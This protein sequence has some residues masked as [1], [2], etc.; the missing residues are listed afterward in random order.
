MSLRVRRT[1]RLLSPWGVGFTYV[2]KELIAR[3]EPHEVG[4]WAQASSGDYAKFL[5]YDPKWAADA[6]RFEV[7]TLD[8][9]G[10]N[11]MA[12]SIGLLLEIGAAEIERHVTMLGDRAAAFAEATNGVEF[13]TPYAASRRAGVL[14]FRRLAMLQA[15]G[16]AGCGR[17]CVTVCAPGASGWRRIST[18]RCLPSWIRRLSC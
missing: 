17:K 12:E 5:D 9:V 10:F 16:A 8:F 4:W 18:I 3:L 6:R 14:A 1:K 7:I 11:A 2:R 13:V 15:S